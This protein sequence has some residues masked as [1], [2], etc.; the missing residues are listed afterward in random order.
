MEFINMDQ[1]DTLENG[2][3]PS[4]TFIDDYSHLRLSY[5]QVRDGTSLSFDQTI[6][7]PT[8]DSSEL[9]HTFNT[10]LTDV[11]ESLAT[12]QDIETDEREKLREY[13]ISQM[14]DLPHPS[15]TM[16]TIIAS[17]SHKMGGNFIYND[18]VEQKGGD[19][20]VEFFPQRRS[21]MQ[22]K[23]GNSSSS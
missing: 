2:E 3:E 5:Y 19:E 21:T 18:R 14:P 12:T 10:A 11:S 16:S 9:N 6:E 8:Q 22:P 20:D 17:A 4:E 7:S 15:F 13:Y 23:P 1:E